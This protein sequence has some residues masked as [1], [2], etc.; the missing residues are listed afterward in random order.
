MNL[1]MMKS[2]ATTFLFAWGALLFI[3]A[4]SVDASRLSGLRGG[5][6]GAFDNDRALSADYDNSTTP[7]KQPRIINGNDVKDNRYAY[8]GLM[9]S[10]YMCGAAMI[11]PRLAL[12][13]AHCAG[14]APNLRIGAQDSVRSGKSI[15][16]LHA[17]VH[18]LFD[19]STFRYDAALMYLAEPTDQFIQVDPTELTQIGTEFTVIGFGDINP[20]SGMELAEKLQETEVELVENKECDKMHGGNDEVT[21]D[22]ICAEG[23]DTDSCGGDSG[24]PLIR[25]GNSI[26]ED[27]LAGIVSWGRGCADP[28]F[29]GGE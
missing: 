22:M 9:L 17:V 20:G 7:E 27:R 18:P 1:K 29:P 10:Q 5:S 28:D 25:K 2:Y 15:R 8:F 21:D 6:G 16:I 11:G 13:A 26:A 4:Q 24:G 12:G 14:G 3:L 19:I 23:K